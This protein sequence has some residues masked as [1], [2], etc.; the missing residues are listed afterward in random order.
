MCL[1][2]FTHS[3]DLTSLEEMASLLLACGPAFCHLGCAFPSISHRLA[4]IL[5]SAMTTLAEGVALTGGSRYR[6]LLVGRIV[7]LKS[8]ALSGLDSTLS[9]GKGL[10]LLTTLCNY[11]VMNGMRELLCTHICFHCDPI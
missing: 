5:L 4:A 6:D 3:Q 1:I 8:V 11:F 9:N 7:T 2:F 10:L